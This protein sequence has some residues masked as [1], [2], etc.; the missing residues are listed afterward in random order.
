MKQRIFVRSMKQFIDVTFEADNNQRV[1]T[2]YVTIIVDG[3][4]PCL[5]LRWKI[6]G[7]IMCSAAFNAIKAK[8]PGALMDVLDHFKDTADLPNML[9]IAA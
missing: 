2:A 6:K 8:N 3:H 1:E 5:K 9:E 4:H 7:R